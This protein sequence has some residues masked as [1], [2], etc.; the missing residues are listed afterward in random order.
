ML[1]GNPEQRAL[2]RR[3]PL[4]S[5]RAVILGGQGVALVL[6]IGQEAFGAGDKR[7]PFDPDRYCLL[8]LLRRRQVILPTDV[9]LVRP[10][11]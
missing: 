3:K 4:L 8:T 5:C 9:L 1:Q 7:K 10:S 6:E 11:G 2:I